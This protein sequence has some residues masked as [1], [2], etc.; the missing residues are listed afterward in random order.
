M[1]DK[2]LNIVHVLRDIFRILR[3][4]KFYLPKIKK[5]KNLSIVVIG[6]GPSANEFLEKTYREKYID[7][8]ALNFFGIDN[9]FFVIKPN[10]YCFADQNVFNSKAIPFVVKEKYE[11]LLNSLAKVDWNMTI[12]IPSDF[13]NSKFIE[14]IKNLNLTIL[15]F[16]ITPLQS[17]G[18]FVNKI[19]DLGWGMTTS[20][21]VIISAIILAINL[22]YKEIL[23]TGVEHS[24]VKE[25]KVTMENK[26]TFML[27]HFY[28][29]DKRY[30]IAYS[31]AEFILSQYRLFKSHDKV[32]KYA[33]FKNVK[34]LNTT[35]ESLIDSYDRI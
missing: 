1:E 8:M 20:E 9:M 21:S 5:T 25:L 32:A 13:K 22:N 6:N 18:F 24:W 11:L 31:M 12:F 28:K 2:I 29:S 17:N 23:L 7:S 4:T 10:Y 19:M 26:V 30:D 14:D 27:R 3:H 35:K 33:K 34:I 15:R 16:N